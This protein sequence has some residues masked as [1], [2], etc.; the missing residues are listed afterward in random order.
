MIK[1]KYYPGPEIDITYNNY[2]GA[3]TLIANRTIIFN[4]ADTSKEIFAYNTAGQMISD[5]TVD[6]SNTGNITLVY[7]FQASGNFIQS[8]IHSNSQPF[9]LANYLQQK[10]NN[11]NIIAEKDSSFPYSAG[12]GYVYSTVTDISITY[13]NKPN[14]FHNLYPKRLVALDYENALLDDVPLFWSILQKNNIL[15]EVR[16][17]NPS[18]LGVDPFNN[19]FVYTYNANNYP[20][21]VT[22]TDNQFGEQYRGVY[23]Y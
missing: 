8:T 6:I 20:L 14:P 10:D 16:S 2:V 1:N 11:G 12:N 3:S 21:T 4:G 9:I 23:V 18:S 17:T 15:T 19:T 7:A 13:D 22:V 5:S